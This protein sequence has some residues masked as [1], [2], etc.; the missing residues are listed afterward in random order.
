MRLAGEL[1]AVEGGPPA[2]SLP[3][4]HL[5]WP[6]I[7][8]DTYD[9]VERQLGE[10]ISIYDR[11]G[12]FARV[13]DRLQQAVGVRHALLTNSGTS[14]LHSMYVGCGLGPGDEV[15]CPAYTFFATATPLFFT[16]AVPVL[17]DCGDDGN[18][19]PDAVEAAIGPR[20]AAVVV[21]HMWGIPCDVGR[22]RATADRHCLA[23]L[24]DTSHAFGATVGSQSVGSFGRAAA[25]SLQG[26]K[27]LTGG[28][29]GVLLTNDPEI[30]HRGLALG[31]YNKRC[32]NEIPPEDPLSE[33]AATGM[34]LKLRAHPL[35]A[36]IVEQQLEVFERRLA[37]RG[38]I[39]ARL[40]AGLRDLPG[41]HPVVPATG[42]RSSWYALIVVL[43]RAALPDGVG[44][45]EVHDALLAEGAEEVD[46]PGSTAPLA[47]LPVFRRPGAL[48]PAYKDVSM[49]GPEAFPK[50]T[51]FHCSILKLPVWHDERHEDLVDQYL[52][53]FHKVWGRLGALRRSP[54]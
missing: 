12:V 5:E 22:L 34:G 39:A 19:D 11:S 17:V 48:F 6:V 8:R 26:Q 20:T 37:G 4:P 41:V 44:A 25:Q 50:A 27:P 42:S 52:N 38:R 45:A 24:E 7:D 1:L 16:G 29:G 32:K 54:V 14:A 31:H 18:V 53:A 2:V 51:A 15:V 28:E 36:A 40:V 3:P 9:A 49:L 47:T 10:S 30:H 23:L 43:D 35:A 21:T 33:Y 13:E 46:R